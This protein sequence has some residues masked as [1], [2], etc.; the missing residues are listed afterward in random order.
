VPPG[1]YEL[2]VFDKPLDVVIATL[3]FTVDPSSDGTCN[4]GDP[5]AFGDVPVFNWNNR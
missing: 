1:N 3:A 4:G 5:C 2:K